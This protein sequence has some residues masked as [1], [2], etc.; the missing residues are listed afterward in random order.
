MSSS[1]SPPLLVH[2]A[3]GTIGGISGLLVSYPFDTLKVKMQTEKFRGMIDCFKSSVKQDTFLSLYR[4]ITSPIFGVGLI[5][6]T[7]FTAYQWSR[8]FI[9]KWTGKDKTNEPL[10]KTELF[11]ASCMS[12]FAASFVVT[13]I[14]RIKVVMQTT[15][16]YSSTWKCGIEL[17]KSEGIFRGLFCGLTPTLYRDVPSYGI[18]FLV[19]EQ[20]KKLLLSDPNMKNQSPLKYQ[21]SIILSGGIAGCASW[22]P[23]FPFDVV[24]SRIQSETSLQRRYTSFF[25]CF[26]ECYK[27]GGISIFF[28]GILPSMIRAFMCHGA[29]FLG[30]EATVKLFL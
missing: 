6:A 1:T 11:T 3:S 30:Y 2:F 16:R 24:K 12:R 14:E 27:E 4:G 18:Y 7:A 25:H 5:K 9:V 10:S 13:P 21:L 19:Y 23:I 29:V 8:E 20:L 15:K 26:I 28:R 17:A 22:I